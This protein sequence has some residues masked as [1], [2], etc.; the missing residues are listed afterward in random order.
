MLSGG[1]DS[2]VRRRLRPPAGSRYAPPTPV[3]F[4]PIPGRRVG[5]DP[6]RLA[7][8]LGIDVLEFAFSGGSALDAAAEYTR[9]WA[10]PPSSPNWFVWNPLY[11]VASADGIDVMLDGEGGDELFG[12][13]P[14]LLADLML[15]GRT[16]GS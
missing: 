2:V 1:L 9:R 13:S 7:D 11:E 6:A 8:H 5:A 14:R 3:S 10:L 12:C 15:A 16:S 4:R